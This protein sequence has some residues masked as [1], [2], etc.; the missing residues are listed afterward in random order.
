[1]ERVNSLHTI[2]IL[3]PAPDVL[4]GCHGEGCHRMLIASLQLSITADSPQQCHLIN[5]CQGSNGNTK[6]KRRNENELSN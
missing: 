6:G 5:A 1:M 3:L 2:A 4:T